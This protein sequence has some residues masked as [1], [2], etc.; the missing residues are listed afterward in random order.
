MLGSIVR[1]TNK[2]VTD[3]KLILKKS[4]NWDQFCAQKSLTH[5]KLQAAVGGMDTNYSKIQKLCIV[6]TDYVHGFLMVLEINSKYYP[7]SI[8]PFQLR[9]SV[10]YVKQDLNP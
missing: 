6:P 10:F 1:Y 3:A 8:R 9:C 7:N 2:H 4:L 5:N